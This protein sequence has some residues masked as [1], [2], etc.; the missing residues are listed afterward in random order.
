MT[1]QPRFAEDANYW[2]T[3]V[4]PYESFGKILALLENFDVGTKVLSQATTD[5]GRMALV[6]RFDWFNE[7]HRLLF[8]PLECREP[9]K[10][11]TFGKKKRK[12]SEQAKFQV[13][14]IALYSVKA[15]LTMAESQPSVLY[16]FKELPGI[17]SHTNGLP[18][19][20]GELDLHTITKSLPT[21]QVQPWALL[22]AGDDALEGEYIEAG[23]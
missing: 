14:R 12:H 2:T 9:D 23:E 8:V 11:S 13:A 15:I 4:P 18:F 1:N 3:V 7:G 22:Q 6:I 10:V 20:A 19:T 21:I 5:D 16:G 17:G